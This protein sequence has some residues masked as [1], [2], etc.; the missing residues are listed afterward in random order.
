MDKFESQFAELDV[1]AGVVENS[2]GSAMSS[3]MPEGQIDALLN[4]VGRTT[5]SLHALPNF[6]QSLNFPSPSLPPGPRCSLC[7]QVAEENNMEVV[8]Q[9]AD[10]PTAMPGARE[11]VGDLSVEANSDLER[12]LQELRS[13]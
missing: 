6:T 11:N 13:G 10:V 8:S 1:R 2:M 12:R 5:I 4:E 7:A 9:A 3:S